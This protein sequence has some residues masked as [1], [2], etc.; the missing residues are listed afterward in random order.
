MTEARGTP[1]EP[2]A[3][4]VAYLINQ[5]P[6]VSHSFIRR[7]IHA[8]ERRGVDVRRYAVRG[9]E[10]DAIDPEDIAERSRTRY[11]LRDGIGPLAAATWRTA[12]EA[13]GAFWQALKLA[14]RLGRRAAGLAARG[15]RLVPPHLG[16]VAVLLRGPGADGRAG[17][18]PCAAGPVSRHVRRL[19][20]ERPP[21]ARGAL[22]RGSRA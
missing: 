16:A 3:L 8:L 11:L 14:L 21:A 4:R 7:E 5:Y 9:W 20:G 10:G 1:P 17:P 13:P 2:T 22:G 6:K 12:R 18:L 15:D 19:C